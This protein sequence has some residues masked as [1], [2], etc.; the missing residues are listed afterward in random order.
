MRAICITTY[1]FF[2]LKSI[3]CKFIVNSSQTI[4]Y[5]H[6]F[7]Y[8]RSTK[9]Q[10]IY[11]FV[12]C[13]SIF[14]LLLFFSLD[15]QNDN[16]SVSLFQMIVCFVSQT[17]LVWMRQMT[18]HQW[19]HFKLFYIL[20]LFFREPPVSTFIGKSFFNDYIELLLFRLNEMTIDRWVLWKVR[21]TAICAF[22]MNERKTHMRMLL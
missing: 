3:T 2:H 14:Y 13:N 6:F 21:S 16:S 4:V 17:F 19:V 10:Y 8:L 15:E 22:M 5:L 9:W 12:P 11:K 7:L 18:I 20:F 1:L